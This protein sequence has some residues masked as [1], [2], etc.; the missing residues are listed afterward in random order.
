MEPIKTSLSQNPLFS[1]KCLV[2]LNSCLMQQ[3]G[4]ILSDKSWKTGKWRTGFSSRYT[5]G[6][7]ESTLCPHTFLSNR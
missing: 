5:Q 4:T 3:Q 1:N 7:K 2:Y 6:E